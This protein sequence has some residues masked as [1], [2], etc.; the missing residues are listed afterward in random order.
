METMRRS[1]LSLQ[2][3]MSIAG[4]LPPCASSAFQLQIVFLRLRDRT[5]SRSSV[6]SLIAPVVTV[7]RRRWCDLLSRRS[8]GRV[9]AALSGSSSLR[10][11]VLNRRNAASHALDKP[12]I[13]EQFEII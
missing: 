2:H 10:W 1:C 8:H 7:K 6:A 12:G 9:G 3:V 11:M 13:T 5:G 4:K